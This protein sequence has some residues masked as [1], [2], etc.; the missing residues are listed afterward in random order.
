MQITS[1]KLT[2]TKVQ[3]KIVAD[4]VQ[5]MHS[6]KDR[7]LQSLA[8][9]V[10]VQG[11]RAGKAPL[12]IVE[13]QLDP[14]RLQSEFVDEA[15]NRL[16]IDALRDQKLRPVAAPQVKILKFVPFD[17]L[18]FEAE[19]E[20]VGAVTLPDYKKMKLAKEKPAVT[21]KE[22][23][24]VIAS[25]RAREA[26]R[27][28]VEREAKDGDQVTIDFKGVD[29]KTKEPI[30][31][32]DGKAYPL[33]LGSNTFIPGF[34][35]ALVGLKVGN[36]KTFDLTFPKDYGVAALQNRKVA[37]TVTVQKVEARTEPKLDDAFAAK[38]GPFKTVQDLKDD[39]KKELLA[40]KEQEAEQKFT[41]ELIT[42]IT[43]KA[44]VAIPEVLVNEQIDRLEQEQRQNLMYRGQTWQEYLDAEGLTDKTFRDKQRPAAEL[45][46]KAGLVLA[47]IS[48]KE[49]V[50]VTAKE[51]TE[52]MAALKA[53]Y[54]DAQMQAEL[55]KPEAQRELASR[56]L[57]EKTVAKLAEYAQAK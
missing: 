23:D 34:E 41:D 7:V 10:K 43:E 52:Y 53:R 50:E 5:L 21:A 36:E 57:T 28:V 38:V 22:V 1:K 6:I 4:D 19:V 45:R 54:P 3:L 37:F 24:E 18:E 27:S 11:F 31:G 25:L 42:K 30:N 17:T 47:E 40:R 51:L 55:A 16:Y 35:P 2:D 33:T 14:A 56:L 39:I 8:S 15:I 13:K 26:E 48:D 49:K 9:G 29:A 12:A 20:I 46:V 32:A 44:K